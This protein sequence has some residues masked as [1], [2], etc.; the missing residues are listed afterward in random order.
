MIVT[1]ITYIEYEL[2]MPVMT[3][4]RA[5]LG[6]DK[7]EPRLPQNFL[8]LFIIYFKIIFI[9]YYIKF[10]IIFIFISYVQLILK[11]TS[12]ISIYFILVIFYI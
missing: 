4:T 2:S 8:I 11:I 10:K 6:F 12:T 1:I 7:G 3:I 5:D 9:Y